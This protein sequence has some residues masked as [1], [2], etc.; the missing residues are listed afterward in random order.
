MDY[1]V[2]K[3]SKI[4]LRCNSKFSVTL[5]NTKIPELQKPRVLVLFEIPICVTLD[6]HIF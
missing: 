6:L 1:D 2:I 3:S 5:N 4:K